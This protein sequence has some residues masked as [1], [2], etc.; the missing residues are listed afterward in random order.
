MSFAASV[1]A[2]MLA[3]ASADEFGEVLLYR[4]HGG[5]AH[6][7]HANVARHPLTL[8]EAGLKHSQQLVFEIVISRDPTLGVTSINK[9]LDKIDVPRARG[10]TA[11]TMRVQEVLAEGLGS[12]RIKAVG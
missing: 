12:W 7:V 3:I 10:A 1:T 11:E 4:P 9:G 6:D 2:D 8:N 5:V